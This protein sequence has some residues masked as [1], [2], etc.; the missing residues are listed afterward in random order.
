MVGA[1]GQSNVASLVVI[2][3]ITDAAS[4]SKCEGTIA[5]SSMLEVM[6]SGLQG[7]LLTGLPQLHSRSMLSNVYVIKIKHRVFR[8]LVPWLYYRT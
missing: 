2:A 7:S 1:A 6:S 8:V 3:T 4:T 5:L